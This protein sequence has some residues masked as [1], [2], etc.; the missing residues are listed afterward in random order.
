[1]EKSESLLFREIYIPYYE[2]INIMEVFIYDKFIISFSGN[3]NIR[4]MLEGSD[5]LY[6][7]YG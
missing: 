3:F 4:F 6:Q 7:S 5:D 1:L 2:R